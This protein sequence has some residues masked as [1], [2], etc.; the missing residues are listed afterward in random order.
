M[1]QMS[2]STPET[3]TPAIEMDGES[4]RRAEETAAGA[5]RG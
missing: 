1:D 2:S 3:T 5:I 4:A